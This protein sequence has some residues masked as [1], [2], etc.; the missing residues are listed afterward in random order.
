MI[1]RWLKIVDDFFDGKP[2]PKNQGG[3]AAATAESHTDQKILE[4]KNPATMQPKSSA[5]IEE[6][7]AVSGAASAAGISSISAGSLDKRSKSMRPSKTKKLTAEKRIAVH[8]VAG[9]GRAPFLVALAIV[10]KGCKP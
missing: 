9:L 8:C 4:L 10:F 1:D 5:A 3:A 6:S 7:K 2:S